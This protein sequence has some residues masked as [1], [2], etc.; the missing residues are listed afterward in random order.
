MTENAEDATCLAQT[1]GVGI[2]RFIGLRHEVSRRVVHCHRTLALGCV[3][4]SD[5]WSGLVS[6]AS[7]SSGLGRFSLFKMVLS[8]SSGNID[9]SHGP[10][11]CS[12]TLD[13]ALRAHS[14]WLRSGTS[15]A[16]KRKATTTMMRP[17]PSPNRKPSVRS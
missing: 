1:V 11:F 15:Q 17:R 16:K 4:N 2:E 5:R 14:G 12:T 6:G 10:V 9:I 7:W 8:G 3:N 13:L